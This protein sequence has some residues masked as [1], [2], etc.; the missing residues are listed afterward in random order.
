MW[1]QAWS[2]IKISFLAGIGV[3]LPVILLFIL[4]E[5]VISMTQKITDPIA[6]SLF[7]QMSY[8]R[9]YATEIV[10]LGLLVMLAVAVG[11]VASTAVG[12]KIGFWIESRTLMRFRPYRSFKEFS[13]RLIPSTEKNL[14]QPALLIRAD[15][16]HALVFVVEEL[17]SGYFVIFVPSTPSTVS[18][19]LYVVPQTDVEIL[20]L[21]AMDFIKTISQWGVGMEKILEH[22][23]FLKS[24]RD[25]VDA[26]RFTGDKHKSI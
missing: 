7:P 6:Q 21:P 24:G 9:V 1:R 26:R 18:G 13:S 4:F 8:L 3:L 17:A 12:Q 19:S 2:F 11:I 22:S 14:L 5:K 20:D 25:F 10:T 23:R 15:E 16:M